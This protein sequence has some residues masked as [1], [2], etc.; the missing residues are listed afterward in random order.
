MSDSVSLF[1]NEL[2]LSDY[3]I[4]VLPQDASG[5]T[6]SRVTNGLDS[7]ILK[8]YD[9]SNY[10]PKSF[11]EITNILQKNNIKVPSIYKIDEKSGLM[12]IEDLGKQTIKDFIITNSLSDEK[13][14]PI[15]KDIIDLL[16][17]I[18]K[19]DISSLQEKQDKKVLLQ[20][21]EL[22]INFFPKYVG[23]NIS[24]DEKAEFLSIFDNLIKNFEF[25]PNCFVHRDFHVENIM[26]KDGEY[27]LIDYQDASI[28]SPIYDLVSLTQ[29]ARINVTTRI[30]REIIDYYWTKKLIDFLQIQNEY[31][32]LGAQRNLRILGVFSYHKVKNNNDKYVQFIPRV[33]NYLDSNLSN[34]LLIDVKNWLK[35]KKIIL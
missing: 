32:I 23:I 4:L 18:Q 25:S 19:I 14:L 27:Y 26:I 31:D 9:V 15:Y 12:L 21:L 3:A 22:F 35:I 1:L 28:G 20:G 11:I 17:D 33:L 30:A 2:F 16:I 13:S 5:R 6:Y 8:Q 34:P 10:N 7:F 29:D 24:F